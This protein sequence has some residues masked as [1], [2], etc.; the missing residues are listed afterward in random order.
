MA[1]YVKHIPNTVVM[2]L[3]GKNTKTMFTR[4]FQSVALHMY[5]VILLHV[6]TNDVEKF[7]LEQSQVGF[8]VLISYL[9]SAAP[10]AKLI[11]S[12]IIPRP[13]DFD[14]LGDHVIF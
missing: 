12:T 10:Q 6:G 14:R 7:T 2:A 11:V 8:E 5:A 9:K 4:I 1:G 3:G 13:K